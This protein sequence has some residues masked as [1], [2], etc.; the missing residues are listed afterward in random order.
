MSCQFRTDETMVEQDLDLLSKNS[1]TPMVPQSSLIFSSQ[2][3][4][5]VP[6]SWNLPDI[7]TLNAIR[8]YNQIYHLKKD[9]L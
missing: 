8:I 9:M 4:E 6:L 7:Y 3:K 5:T 1:R 2:G